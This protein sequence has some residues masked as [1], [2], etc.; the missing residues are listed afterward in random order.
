[1]S[2]PDETFPIPVTLT[3]E[4]LWRGERVYPEHIYDPTRIQI[5]TEILGKEV[6]KLV[7][8]QNDAELE[9]HRGLVGEWFKGTEQELSPV[10]D[11]WCTFELLPLVKTK[12]LARFV[13]AQNV[14][15]R[16]ENMSMDNLVLT[17]MP[18]IEHRPEFGE[19]PW[20][21]PVIRSIFEQHPDVYA[22]AA[23]QNRVNRSR[24]GFNR[25]NDPITIVTREDETQYL[26][27]GNG[28]LYAALMAGRD[29]IRTWHGSMTGMKL[30]NYWVSTGLLKDLCYTAVDE[31]E[32][33]PE[34]ADAALVLLRAR[35]ADNKVAKANYHI[36]IK[37]YFPDITEKLTDVL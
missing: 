23:E 26:L 35:L 20:P 36:W 1:M 11:F 2:T 19:G 16:P 25:D 9:A 28:R 7:V 17:W 22:E 6:A 8:A 13:T 10:H 5:A 32:S 31:A 33:N 30:E 4:A 14:D 37:Q 3:P 29:E 24:Y 21:V 34:V 15:W 27:D 12:R 18:F